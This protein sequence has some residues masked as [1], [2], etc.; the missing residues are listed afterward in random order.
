MQKLASKSY[1]DTT[2]IKKAMQI[3]NTILEQMTINM[4]M[5]NI[6][7]AKGRQREC[8]KKEPWEPSNFRLAFPAYFSW[9]PFCSCNFNYFLNCLH[10]KTRNLV[11]VS[12]RYACVL[13]SEIIY[14]VGEIFILLSVGG[15]KKI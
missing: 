11:T 7:P 1:F 6:G 10:H 3:S 13:N 5:G 4:T 2:E 12:K 9:C 14:N 15:V 8:S